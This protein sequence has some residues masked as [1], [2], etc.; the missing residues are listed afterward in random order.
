[1][2]RTYKPVLSSEVNRMVEMYSQGVPIATIARDLGRSEASVARHLTARGVKNGDDQKYY[3]YELVTRAK[4]LRLQHKGISEIAT[5][6]GCSEK[7]VRLLF[8]AVRKRGDTDM[9]F[10]LNEPDMAYI[11]SHNK[12]MTETEIARALGF[13]RNTIVRFIDCEGL[14]RRKDKV[15]DILAR[16]PNEDRASL[17]EEYGMTRV[18]LS[19]L[20]SR[21]RRKGKG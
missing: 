7:E 18:T 6:L 16:Y 11:R 13:C 8:K 10:N 19:K 4:E 3:S 1:M 17:A 20:V 2:K 9:V 12:T 15:A 21:E 14:M 5:E